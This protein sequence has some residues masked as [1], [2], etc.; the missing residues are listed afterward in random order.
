MTRIL[1]CVAAAALLAF[2]PAAAAVPLR[3]RPMPD[4]LPGVAAFPRLD[5]HRFDRAARRINAALAKADARV[6]AAAIGC[7]E[8]PPAK[9]SSW[10]RS[11]TV[12][13]RGPRYLALVARDDWYCGAYPDHDVVALVYDLRS[14]AP[15]DW[16]RL[17]PRG[18]LAGTATDTV[19]DGTTV[20]LARAPA[21]AAAYQRIG[22]AATL[23]KECSEVFDDK[24]VWGT[25]GFQLWPDARA[26]GLAMEN[27]GL[28]HVVAAC[29]ATVVIPAAELRR[30]GV[31]PALLDPLT[32]AHREG[33]YGVGR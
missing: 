4:V 27:P 3:L 25:P 32:T 15:V 24:T 23:P 5:A 9:G 21:L 11:V 22:L 18:L 28:P 7:P 33:L 16:A 29:G 30:L 14:G 20:G 12:A 10:K 26:D 13:M 31:G 6:R 2:G 19:G 1:W 17:L 8:P